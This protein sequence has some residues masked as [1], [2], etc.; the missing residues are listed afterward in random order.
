[1]KLRKTV[2][3]L[4]LALLAATTCVPAMAAE[5]QLPPAGVQTADNG[6]APH[7]EETVW[8]TRMYNGK[9]QKRLWSITNECWLTDWI[10]VG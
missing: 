5:V 8:Y 6:I 4:T 2:L 9:L 10:D 1:M 7:A 3:S